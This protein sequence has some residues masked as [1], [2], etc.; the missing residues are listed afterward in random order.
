MCVHGV[1]MEEGVGVSEYR[2]ERVGRM[3]KDVLVG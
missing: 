1:G 2:G 3:G